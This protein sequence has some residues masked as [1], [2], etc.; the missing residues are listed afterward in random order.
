MLCYKS[1][2]LLEFIVNLIYIKLVPPPPVRS[3]SDPTHTASARRRSCDDSGP[4]RDPRHRSPA[5]MRS[6]ILKPTSGAAATG[7]MLPEEMADVEKAAVHRLEVF[8]AHL[9]GVSV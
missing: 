5:Q 7:A 1:C 8:S 3:V 2:I 4:S 9:E 6:Y